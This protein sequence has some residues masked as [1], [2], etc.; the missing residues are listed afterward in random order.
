MNIKAVSGLRLSVASP[1]ESADFYERIGFIIVR[2]DFDLA[3]VRSNWFWIE[4]TVGPPEASEGYQACLS[5]DNVFDIHK[6]LMS[7]NLDPTAV[8]GNNGRKE[9][10]IVDPDGHRLVFF[11]K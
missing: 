8:I 7:L 4:L 1:A 10:S 2:K 6:E 11:H 9:T 5:V 3:I